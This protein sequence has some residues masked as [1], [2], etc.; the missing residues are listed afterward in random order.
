MQSKKG[1]CVEIITPCK[2]GALKRKKL[3]I[4]GGA[5]ITQHYHNV[6]CRALSEN[7]KINK[8][9]IGEGTYGVVYRLCKVT[10]DNKKICNIVMKVSKHPCNDA[11]KNEYIQEGLS[12][13]KVS[14]YGL[15]PEPYYFDKC[16]DK[17]VLYMEMVKGVT[18]QDLFARKQIKMKILEK[19]MSGLETIGKILKSGHGDPSFANAIYKP[20][21]DKVIFIDIEPEVDGRPPDFDFGLLLYYSFIPFDFYKSIY[22]GEFLYKTI[23]SKIKKF[24]NLGPDYKAVISDLHVLIE[25]L[26]QAAKYPEDKKALFPEILKYSHKL[27]SDDVYDLFHIKGMKIRV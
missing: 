3:S 5:L 15:S 21:E 8:Y 7:K 20:Q 26:T 11:V 27:S 4:K 9:I 6:L 18:L 25:M 22:L 24:E 10:R 13:M 17:C 23:Y 1:C 16:G 12:M 19:F 14:K 2:S